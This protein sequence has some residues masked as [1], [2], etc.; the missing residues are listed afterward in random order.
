MAFR[1][2]C[3]SVALP[4]RGRP[5][6]DPTSMSFSSPVRPP[7]M[8]TGVL[9]AAV[10]LM[11]AGVA[12]AATAPSAHPR[13]S[14]FVSPAGGPGGSGSAD[15]PWDLATAL[16]GAGGRVQPGD[17]VWLRGGTYHGSFRTDLR[18][19]PGQWI[20]FRQAPGER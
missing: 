7:R 11:V 10:L 4:R 6:Q 8:P 20:V 17:T 9:K 15:R 12:L 1:R 3:P 16:G 14:H 5:E 19:S 18:G 13:S 2:R